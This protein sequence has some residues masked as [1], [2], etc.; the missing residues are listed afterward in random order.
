[1]KMEEIKIEVT[2]IKVLNKYNQAA[3]EM[4]LSMGATK[5]NIKEI[6]GQL[7]F[8]DVIKYVK[9]KEGK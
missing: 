4:A 8:V 2:K 9:Q 6:A 7:R 1:M 5:E 3:M